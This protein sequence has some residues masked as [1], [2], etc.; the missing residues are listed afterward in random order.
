MNTIT[1]LS[2]LTEVGTFIGGV[3]TFIGGVGTF[4]GGVIIAL[5]FKKKFFSS[6][7]DQVVRYL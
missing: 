1:I 6:S 7:S 2:N 5:D 4:I 3:G